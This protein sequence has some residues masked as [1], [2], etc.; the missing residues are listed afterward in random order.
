MI[1]IV[2]T[3]IAIIVVAACTPP[4]PVQTSPSAPPTHVYGGRVAT[5]PTGLV[6]D[7]KPWWPSGFN[8]YQLGTDWSSNLGCGAEVDLD[9]YFDQ[10]P[11]GSLTRFNLFS[12]LATSRETGRLDFSRFDAVFAAATRHDRMVLPVLTGSNGACEDERYKDRSWYVDGWK[13]DQGPADLT[14]ERWM[15]IAVQRWGGERSLAGWEIVGEPEAG[16]CG[17]EGCDWQHRTCPA[18]AAAVLRTFFDTVGTELTAIDARHPIFAGTTGGDQCGIAG[19]DMLTV[20]ASPHIDVLD[21]HDYRDAEGVP[22]ADSSL[23]ERLA[24]A[25]ELG[26]PLIVN[27]LGI[28]GGSCLSLPA[29]AASFRSRIYANRAAGAAGTLLWA[30]VPDPR[31]GECTYDIGFDDPAWAVVAEVVD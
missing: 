14:F 25:H 9:H 5:T 27:E 21:F 29:R 15:M 22:P 8:A 11:R 23:P 30:F 16:V 1:R 24:Q 10:V 18:G 12:S 31:P 17:A 3:L 7:G 2:I 19:G 28:K 6:L 20:G 26:K 4:E 13:R